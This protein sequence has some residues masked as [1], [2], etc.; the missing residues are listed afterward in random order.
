[1]PFP[2]QAEAV[3]DAITFGEGR[4][5]EACEAAIAELEH[6]GGFRATAE[7]AERAAK[8]AAKLAMLSIITSEHA[9]ICDENR[10]LHVVTGR[11]A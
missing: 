5:L 1:M 10:M 11:A 9:W 3:S 8:I 7:Q 2:Y 4:L 6:N